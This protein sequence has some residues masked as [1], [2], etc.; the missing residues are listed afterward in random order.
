MPLV[1]PK[2]APLEKQAKTHRSMSIVKLQHRAQ[3]LCVQIERAR[4]T[5]CLSIE[6]NASEMGRHSLNPGFTTEWESV[7]T[8]E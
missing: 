6:H 3:Y 5:C 2:Q 4:P 7:G 8:T 1:R